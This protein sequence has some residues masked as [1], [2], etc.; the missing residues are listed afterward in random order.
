MPIIT[1]A[2]SK[3]GAG[4]TTLARLLVGTAAQQGYQ[5][6]ALDADFNRTF[7]EWIEND[8]KLP[9]PVPVRYEIEADA[10]LPALSAL[11]EDHDFI[12]IDTAGAALEATAYAMGCADVVLI[13]ITVN[14]ADVVEANKTMQLFERVKKETRSSA[15]A[16]VVFTAFKPRTTLG[17]YIE[18]MVTDLKLPTLRSKL[19]DLIA[20]REMSFNG[21][22]PVGGAVGLQVGNFF[23]EVMDLLPAAERKKHVA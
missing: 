18:E 6:A 16:R 21:E 17:A 22:V 1:V 3:G 7:G 14:A 5:V 4:K 10:M 13:P 19:M 11:T 8:A 15:K 23:D 20:F 12:V 9:S 2:T